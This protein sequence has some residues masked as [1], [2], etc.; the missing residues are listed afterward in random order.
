A[1]Y[2][3]RPL[4]CNLP[5]RS[6][7]QVIMAAVGRLPGAS[8]QNVALRGLLWPDSVRAPRKFRFWRSA[9]NF[10]EARMLATAPAKTHYFEDLEIGQE[11]S[12]SRTVTEADIVAYAALSGDYNP[13]HI[14]QVYAS[15]TLFK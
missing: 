14:D 7:V 2:R 6:C 10:G 3:D 13:V 4:R 12:L 15:K 11:A 1:L 8:G 5:G 9:Q